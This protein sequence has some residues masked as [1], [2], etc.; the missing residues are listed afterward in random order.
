MIPKTFGENI[1]WTDETKV[2]FLEGVLRYT[3]RKS[4]MAHQKK[5]ITLKVK[6]GCGS[7]MVWVCLAASGPGR[8][9]AVNGTM[10]SAVHQ[11]I[12]KENVGHLFMT[13]S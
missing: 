13:S 2:E 8:L 12:L 7:V 11:N 1:P 6:S 10:N 4:D 5:K 3:W 9:A